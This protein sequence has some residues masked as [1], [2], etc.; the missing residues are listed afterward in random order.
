[1]KLWAI[2]LITKKNNI[3]TYVDR[4]EKDAVAFQVVFNY[5]GAAA[6]VGN[7]VRQMNKC[8]LLNGKHTYISIFLLAL[9]II[10]SIV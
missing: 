5:M 1:M 8:K 10:S 9:S 3:Y 2:V 7:L 6:G 4:Y